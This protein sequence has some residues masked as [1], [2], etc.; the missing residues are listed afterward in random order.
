MRYREG[1]WVIRWLALCLL[2]TILT[3]LPFAAFS[4]DQHGTFTSLTIEQ[5]LGIRVD[6]RD[7]LLA[8]TLPDSGLALGLGSSLDLLGGDLS[9]RAFP[10]RKPAVD[11]TGTMLLTTDPVRTLCYFIT[12]YI[13][14]KEFLVWHEVLLAVL[15]PGKGWS[16]QLR[17]ATYPEL[18]DLLRFGAQTGYKVYRRVVP[19]DRP[20]FVCDTS[21]PD[22]RLVE[23]FPSDPNRTSITF[24][25]GGTDGARPAIGPAGPL[26]LQSPL[27]NLSVGNLGTVGALR[28]GQI[29]TPPFGNAWIQK[30]LRVGDNAKV[31]EKVG[32]GA[33]WA[34]TARLNIAG[35]PAVSR[36]NILLDATN[37]AAPATGRTWE[38]ASTA[39]GDLELW[40]NSFAAGPQLR[41]D[42]W[43]PAGDVLFNIGNPD[44]LTAGTF[45]IA[46]VAV[47][48]G[49]PCVGGS[50]RLEINRVGKV[51]IG[52]PAV[53]G[54][55]GSLEVA[56][57]LGV[58]MP[59]PAGCGGLSVVGNVNIGGNLQIAWD[60]D[61][62]GDAIVTGDLTVLGVKFFAQPHP[63]DPTKV[64]TYAALEGPEA[65][66]YVRGTAQLV[67]GEVTI[68][69]P[70]SFRLVTGEEGLTVQVT[71]LEECNGLY[72]VEKSPERIVVKELMGGTSNARFDYLV[73]GVRK[74][75]EDFEPISESAPDGA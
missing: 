44:T 33:L 60:A 64:I 71:P 36:A 69:L 6:I 57:S 58:G 9:V 13:D 41:W 17:W 3:A 19:E 38:L 46:D 12:A 40:D 42:M 75:Y 16:I 66:T 51:S 18:T 43:G 26:S 37:L 54:P 48:P 34:K 27:G 10:P 73:Q 22:I 74:G 2:L 68:E 4:E 14:D 65:G 1:N 11:V 32:I 67:D 63:M 5:L 29:A 39:F 30:C 70:E 53:G 52:L 50:P 24:T 45:T 62:L 8:M 31:S 72:I 28:V 59:A 21:D 15:D 56:Y 55:A 49:M 7:P 20:I 61:I 25:D 35:L 47:G 23:K